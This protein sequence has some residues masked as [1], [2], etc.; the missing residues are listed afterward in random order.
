LH[1]VSEL[2]ED[3]LHLEEEV[4]FIMPS[5]NVLSNHIKASSNGSDNSDSLFENLGKLVVASYYVGAYTTVSLGVEKFVARA[6]FR[7]NTK[8]P[9]RLKAISYLEKRDRLRAAI[10][11]VAGGRELKGS[12]PFAE[13]IFDGV[14]AE[15][16]RV[17]G[18]P[19]IRRI[20]DEIQDMNRERRR[21]VA[22]ELTLKEE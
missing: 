18:W 13:R 22:A 6:V 16:G 5:F 10:I 11:K 15:L 21:E 17:K 20:K 8:T 12:M 14:C 3:R 9:R 7:E 19:T 2:R 1:L 4:N